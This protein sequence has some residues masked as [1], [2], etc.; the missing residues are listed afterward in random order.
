MVYHLQISI[1]KEIPLIVYQLQIIKLKES[2]VVYQL[3]IIKQKLL[4]IKENTQVAYHL[5]IVK[6]K[7]NPPVVPFTDN[8]TKT[9]SL[10][11]VPFTDNRTKI[12]FDLYL[13]S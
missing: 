2:T 8:Q 5:Q 6:L 13:Y 1:L 11:C 7:E 4:K 10:S 12:K 9:K 3:Q